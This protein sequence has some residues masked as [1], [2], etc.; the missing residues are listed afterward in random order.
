MTQASLLHELRAG[1]C[2]HLEPLAF[3]Q[4]AHTRGSTLVCSLCGA[5]AAGARGQLVASKLPT[6]S[7]TLEAELQKVPG[8]HVVHSAVY[9]SLGCGEIFC[10][11]ECEAAA[12]TSGHKAMCVGPLTEEAPM[13]HLK[14]VALHSGLHET[15]TLAIKVATMAVADP[16]GPASRFLGSATLAAQPAW[17]A[18][19]GNG[20]AAEELLDYIGDVYTGPD[21]PSI[22]VL[23]W[24]LLAA[25]V[26]LSSCPT[27]TAD[28]WVRLLSYAERRSLPVERTSP[29]VDY[30]RGVPAE[31]EEARLWLLRWAHERS[32]EPDDDG[33]DE[34]DEHD[35][36][37]HGE[38]VGGAKSGADASPN[39]ER[40]YAWLK[41]ECNELVPKLQGRCLLPEVE[42]LAP[43]CLPT[44]AVAVDAASKQ[45]SLTVR[46]DATPSEPLCFCPFSTSLPR[47]ERIALHLA[48][49]G[50]ACVC[51]RCEFEASGAVATAAAATG[52]SGEAASTADAP[53][54]RRL[55]KLAQDDH[56]IDDANAAID[57]LLCIDGRD[58]DALYARAR[59]AG[60]A[61]R[62]SEAHRLLLEAQPVAPDHP[63]IARTLGEA[64]AYAAHASPAAAAAAP[65]TAAL[66]TDGFERI[67]VSG[68][69]VAYV[70][71]EPLLPPAEC[72]QAIADAEAHVAA[73]QGGSWATARHFAVPTTDLQVCAVPSLLRWFGGALRERI[74]P[75]LGAQYGVDPNRMRVIDAFLVKYEAERGQAYL[76][77]HSDQSEYSLTLPLNDGF[78]GGGTYFADLG[79][80]LNCCTGGLV[81]F[82]GALTHGAAPISSGVR[83]V[84]VAF[85]YEYHDE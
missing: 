19:D 58:G 21:D 61:D 31:E 59:V 84:I 28:S 75:Q 23:S 37:E 83:Y 85:L 47:D 25:A 5:F 7:E 41:A 65:A 74:F 13:Y 51:P 54:L 64:E 67:L 63:E 3:A 52:G 72:A 39:M 44:C 2:L 18:A 40:G 27:L 35:E 8:R 29:L 6:S 78:G 32:D 10:S 56:R 48:R 73:T 43:T 46:S 17:T 77:L 60:W 66:S 42:A 26:D 24:H 33:E 55:V 36:H 76:P 11:A 34:H 38:A 69:L 45:L 15:M 14:V 12:Q 70:S 16:S 1:K 81:T 68:D 62:W 57:A 50:V 82:P 53:T 30:L 9:C 20:A 71:R 80:A 4:L 49:G 79:R 22:D